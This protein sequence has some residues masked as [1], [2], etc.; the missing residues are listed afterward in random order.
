M[1]LFKILKLTYFFI[2]FIACSSP[3]SIDYEDIIS[4]EDYCEWCESGRQEGSRPDQDTSNSISPPSFLALG[5]SYTIGEGVN[6]DQRWPNQFV[7]VANYN[8][9]Q[10]DQP[11]II[12][13]TGWK[14]YDLLNAIKQTN[15]TKKYDYIS[16]LIGVNNQFN[17]RPINEFEKDLDKLMDEM[18]RLKKNGGSI[19]IISIPDWGSSTFGENMDRNQISTEINSFNNSLKSFANINGLKYV[20]VTEISRRAINEPNLITSDN[21]HPSGLMYLEWAKKIFYVWIN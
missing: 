3:N 12:A 16:L 15:F 19:T 1:N 10:I 17:S 8:G 14:T 2:F 6:G 7:D 9:I 4:N 5:D 11:I 13:E 21:L 18:K 20:D